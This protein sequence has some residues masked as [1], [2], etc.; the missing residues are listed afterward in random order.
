MTDKILA[1]TLI[2]WSIIISEVTASPTASELFNFSIMEYVPYI[3]ITILLAITLMT[4]H[5]A[6]C[7]Y[8]EYV[9]GIFGVIFFMYFTTVFPFLFFY[10]KEGLTLRT[11]LLLSFMC[12]ALLV[13]CLTLIIVCDKEKK[14]I[15]FII[16]AVIILSA[17]LFGVE[18]GWMV[19]ALMSIKD[20]LKTPLEFT[21]F[22]KVLC[23]WHQVSSASLLLFW[24]VIW[25]LLCSMY[26]AP[27]FTKRIEECLRD[28]SNTEGTI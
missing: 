28:R 13:T 18:A 8:K 20:G 4:F 2:L 3:T 19:N 25:A 5:F 14:V 12:L 6:E 17:Y 11:T 16:I 1:T 24:T 10:I 27:H 21:L 7:E 9:I 15:A 23:L 22:G 26:Y